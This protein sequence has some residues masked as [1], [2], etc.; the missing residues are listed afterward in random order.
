MSPRRIA[1]ALL[2]AAS[3]AA[4]SS[5]LAQAP[6]DPVP[7]GPS[8]TPTETTPTPTPTPTP[9]PGDPA[10]APAPTPPPGPAGIQGESPVDVP[11]V[12]AQLKS[13]LNGVVGYGFAISRNGQLVPGGWGG[14]GAARIAADGYRAFAGNTRME[15]MSVTKNV[16]AVALQKLLDQRGISVDTP[17]SAYLPPTWTKSAGFAKT[18]A[19]PITFAHL[20]AHT[21]G[22]NQAI[23]SMSAAQSANV[24]NT[25]DGMKYIV[26]FGA[27]PGANQYKN[28]N[29]ALIR[30]LIARL[31]TSKAGGP[32]TKTT[33]ANYAAR[34]L[35][36]LNT[37]VLAAAGIKKVKCWS[38]DD[39]NAAMVYDKDNLG[40]GGAVVERDGDSRQH[41]GGHAGLHMSAVDLVR[42]WSYVRHTDTILAPVIRKQMFD[43]ELGWQPS[44]NGGV[45]ASAGIFWHA[46]DGF[47]AGGRESHSCVMAATQR[48]ELAVVLNSDRPAGVNQCT[49]LR[50]AFNAGRGL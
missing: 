50:G 22:V 32:S 43:R 19:D 35:K 46:G 4:P 9:P 24:A 44:S 14:V 18:A 26:G 29:Y 36:Y 39:A 30:V 33:K 17:V 34:T 3:L 2:A 13:S 15:V 37:K 12:V 28:A 45:A 23:A 8:T 20:L 38:D 40:Q 1:V 7:G 16:T 48:Y 11:K 25:W 31:W 5:I 42:L 6:T 47:Y 10:P 49:A 27:T 41:C 21:S